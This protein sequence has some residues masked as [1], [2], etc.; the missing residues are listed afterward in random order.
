[1]TGAG[2]INQGIEIYLPEPS[3]AKVVLLQ[4]VRDNQNK[5]DSS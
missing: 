2:L 4:R 5:E 3:T 1:M